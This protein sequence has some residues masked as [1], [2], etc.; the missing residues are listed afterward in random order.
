MIIIPPITQKATEKELDNSYAFGI[1]VF[2]FVVVW[3]IAYYFYKIIRFHEKIFGGFSK[4]SE[5]PYIS[6]G[7]GCFVF[8]KLFLKNLKKLCRKIF[9]ENL[10]HIFS[11]DTG[12]TPKKRPAEKTK[13]LV[14]AEMF[15]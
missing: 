11:K 2:L 9:S 1:A 8:Q 6:R 3:G 7:F 10:F 15:L 14:V 13:N 12:K 5:K 4:L